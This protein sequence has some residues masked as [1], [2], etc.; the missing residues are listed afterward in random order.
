MPVESL[1]IYSRSAWWVRLRSL[2]PYALI[3]LIMPGGS[4]MALL[5][6]LYRHRKKSVRDSDVISSLIGQRSLGEAIETPRTSGI[7]LPIGLR[8]VL[9]EDACT[10]SH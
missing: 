6:W 1:S 5:L 9:E 10:G 4:L 3:E 8:L 2:A 7:G